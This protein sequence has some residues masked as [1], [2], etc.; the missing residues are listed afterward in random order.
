VWFEEEMDRVANDAST[1]FI[2][3]GPWSQSIIALYAP[4]VVGH[5][6]GLRGRPPS[7][8]LTPAAIS[9]IRG[10]RRPIVAALGPPDEVTAIV[11]T[12][13]TDLR[14]GTKVLD[15]SHDDALGYRLVVFAMPDAAYL[16]FT[17]TADVLPRATGSLIGTSVHVRAGDAPGFVTY[18]PYL[19]LFAGRY[20][21]ALEYDS[22][23][24]LGVSAGAFEVA[25]PELGDA[26]RVSI[27]GSSGQVAIARLPFDVR[28]NSGRW[29][30]RTS[31]NATGELT[32]RSI[33]LSSR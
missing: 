24:P 32:I 18:G 2:A 6:V 33:T 27:T 12:F 13:D 21:V 14:V 31:W 11:A 3:V 5:V 15:V 19:P 28:A 25:S 17:L 26:G 30:F 22:N 8:R 1:S 9:E 29:E 16:P 23:L 4:H 20:E 7:Q 10:G